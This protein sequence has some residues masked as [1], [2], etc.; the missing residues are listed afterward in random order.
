MFKNTCNVKKQQH[1]P[2]NP[3][4]YAACDDAS[5][6][7]CSISNCSL[8]LLNYWLGCIHER[9]RWRESC[10]QIGYPSGQGENILPVR[11]F[12]R[13]SRKRNFCNKCIHTCNK[14]IFLTMFVRWKWLDIGLFFVCVFSSASTSFWSTV[15][16]NAVCVAC[17]QRR[18]ERRVKGR[19][20]WEEKERDSLRLLLSPFSP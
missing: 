3:T 15:Y 11:N 9:E 6:R 8:T 14:Y 16:K 7:L 18:G 13:W 17:V 19:G 2:A 4:G 10:I 5:F 1:S 12:P 20:D